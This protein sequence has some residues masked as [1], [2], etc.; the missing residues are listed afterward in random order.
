[1]LE[2]IILEELFERDVCKERSVWSVSFVASLSEAFYRPVELEDV[3]S[4][5]VEKERRVSIARR[6]SAIPSSS[7]AASMTSSALIR[8]KSLVWR[9]ALRHAERVRAVSVTYL[10]LCVWQSRSLFV[11][12]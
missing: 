7:E 8:H 6:T 3:G 9:L 5:V 2:D 12:S 1:M 4:S 10:V 11:R